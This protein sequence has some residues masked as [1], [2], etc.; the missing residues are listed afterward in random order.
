MNYQNK[1]FAKLFAG[2]VAAAVVFTILPRF[3]FASIISLVQVV[4]WVGFF[5]FLYQVFGRRYLS[6]YRSRRRYN[7][8]KPPGYYSDRR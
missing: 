5:Y 6:N 1:R 8:D 7:K 3:V 2:L 4:F